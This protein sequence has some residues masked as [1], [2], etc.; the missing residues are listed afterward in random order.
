VAFFLK[1]KERGGKQLKIANRPNHPHPL[2]FVSFLAVTISTTNS[3]A[4]R[5]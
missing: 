3:T 2:F 1:K 5:V 4:K